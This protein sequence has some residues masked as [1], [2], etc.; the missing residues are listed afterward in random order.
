ML[1]SQV[2]GVDR[3]HPQKN[4]AFVRCLLLKRSSYPEV[5][6]C[7]S[8]IFG[9]SF[10]LSGHWGGGGGQL[11]SRPEQGSPAGW[12]PLPLGPCQVAGVAKPSTF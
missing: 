12:A 4:T 11:E 6:L 8:V 10:T 5:I 1:N 2:R 3:V 9:C 7:G